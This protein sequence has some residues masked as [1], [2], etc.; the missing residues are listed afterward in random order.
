[1]N[2][3]ITGGAGYIGS[4]T[5]LCL[6]QAGI[7]VVALDNLSN[8]SK[9]AVERVSRLASGSLEFI[10]GSVNDSD[11]LAR[12]FNDHEIDSVVHFAGLKAVGE[13]NDIPLKYFQNNVAGTLNLLQSMNAAG[14]KR[15]VFSSS[16]TVYGAGANIPYV[17]SAGRGQTS[18]P[19]GETK[20]M[21]ERILEDISASDPEWEVTALRYFNPI[22]AHD[23]GI[24]GEDPKGMPNNLI[25]FISQVAVGRRNELSIFGGDYDTPDGTCR[26][27]Y[28]H[29]MDLAEGHVVAIER[30]KPG[31]NA[32]NMGTGNP[33]SV[34]EIVNAFSKE[35]GICIPYSIIDRR[36]GD[37]PEVWADV[38]KA[39][40]ELGW[41]AKR[42]VAE[43]IRD[44]WNWQRKNPN[45]YDS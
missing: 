7:S 4:H 24:I 32:F 44:T 18:N 33:S 36:D 34:L 45:G 20:A 9:A 30:L 15:F 38:T 11:L 22:G 26:R 12:L 23:S 13:S 43:M 2:V 42:S 16:A 17:E 35:A 41:E 14:I 8:G 10:E 31:F 28:L 27:D 37:L 1:M 29:V 6:L 5:M 40:T 39:K 3:L 25:P 19:Y 21:V